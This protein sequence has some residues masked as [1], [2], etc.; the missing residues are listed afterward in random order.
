[1]RSSRRRETLKGEPVD[2]KAQ[3]TATYVRAGGKCEVWM[4]ATVPMPTPK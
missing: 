4:Q 1:M 2:F 3:W